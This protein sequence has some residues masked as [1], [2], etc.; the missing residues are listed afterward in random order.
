[1][2]EHPIHKALPLARSISNNEKGRPP[3][4]KPHLSHQ[5]ISNKDRVGTL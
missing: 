4:K 3:L 2:R 1:M 5:H